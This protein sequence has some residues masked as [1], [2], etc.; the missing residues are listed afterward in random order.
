M[1]Q[2]EWSTP[3]KSRIITEVNIKLDSGHSVRRLW[4]EKA[5]KGEIKNGNWP[6]R[7][8]YNR[9]RRDI[10]N[11][12]FE[13]GT[14]RTRSKSVNLGRP[15][16]ISAEQLNEIAAG[17]KSY[18]EL[19]HEQHAAQIGC[20]TR[21]V[22]RACERYMPPIRRGSEQRQK[23]L[24]AGAQS[25]SRMEPAP[26]LNETSSLDPAPQSACR[27]VA[28]MPGINNAQKTIEKE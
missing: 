27:L 28:K 3:Q 19:S 17:D 7:S 24:R 21:T 5:E 14:R 20:S 2:N 25:H 23:G 11:N 10:Q 12:G 1:G 16:V 6:V 22:I 4:K 15:P 13:Q 26:V 9:W 18:R 8:T